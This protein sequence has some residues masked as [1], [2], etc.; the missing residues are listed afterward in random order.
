VPV[1]GGDTG[2]EPCGHSANDTAG[3]AAGRVSAARCD[4]TECWL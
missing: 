3:Y 1:V 2:S 4:G